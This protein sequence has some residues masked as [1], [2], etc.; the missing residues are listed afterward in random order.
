VL[1]RDLHRPA[2]AAH[3]ASAFTATSVAYPSSL[4]LGRRRG[5]RTTAP[6]SSGRLSSA[7]CS[8]LRPSGALSRFTCPFART[9]PAPLSPDT[10]KLPSS[11]NEL[12]CRASRHRR[13]RASRPAMAMR[14]QD[15][16]HRLLQL[17]CDNVHPMD[18]SISE[19]EAFAV[20][21]RHRAS[22]RRTFR[23]A[24]APLP[25]CRRRAAL[26]QR[27]PRSMRA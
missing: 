12:P 5:F 1:P 17:T 8:I 27:G 21:D 13:R 25:R 15:A 18:R 10:M 19:H 26:R 2:F 16:S 11:R 22:L 7:R 20:T 3:L 24:S 23:S 14:R 9:R 6:M 4:E